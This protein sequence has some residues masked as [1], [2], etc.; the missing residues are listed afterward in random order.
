M[1]GDME[2]AH[3]NAYRSEYRFVIDGAPDKELHDRLWYDYTAPPTVAW[4]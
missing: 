1:A 2:I 4:E 3:D